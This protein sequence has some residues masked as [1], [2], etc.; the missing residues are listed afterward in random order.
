MNKLIT[1]CNLSQ[2]LRILEQI[3]EQKEIQIMK[4][5]LGNHPVIVF[6][7]LI[8]SCIAIF[9]FITGIDNIRQFFSSNTNYSNTPNQPNE[10]T[11]IITDTPAEPQ[12]ISQE[13]VKT[14]NYKNV[15]ITMQDWN[16]EPGQGKVKIQ[17]LAGSKPINR[18]STGITEADFD[19]LGVPTANWT[20]TDANYADINGIVEFVVK[21]GQYALLDVRSLLSGG[22][23]TSIAGMWG[24]IGQ[25]DTGHKMI[26]VIFPVQEGKMTTVIVHLALLQFGI[27]NSNGTQALTNACSFNLYCQGQDISG[28]MI[29]SDACGDNTY[30]NNTRCTNLSGIAEFYVAPGVYFLIDGKYDTGNGLNYDGL[31]ETN[32]SIDGTSEYYIELN[33]PTR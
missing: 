2:P 24:E 17:W 13:P 20:S 9:A 18:K 32:I 33:V 4:S 5:N 3:H 12:V 6:I 19:V 29:P 26:M 11:Y 25:L 21:P 23:S 1:E 31:I 15:T 16:E 7:G 10:N 14:R 22:E 8:A 27:L 30:N 28:N